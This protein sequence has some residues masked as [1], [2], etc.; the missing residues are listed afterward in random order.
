MPSSVII[1][2]AGYAGIGAARKLLDEGRDVFKVIVLEGG[3]RVGGRA[4]TVNGKEMGGTYFHGIYGHP[5]YEYA[6][7][8]GIVGEPF[9]REFRWGFCEPGKAAPVDGSLPADIR[10]AV[11]EYASVLPSG[12][13]A[14]YK[15]SIGT[16]LH[17]KFAE[18][19][20]KTGSI[21]LKSRAWRWR[22]LVTRIASG[23]ESSADVSAAW[24]AGAEDLEGPNF[25]CPIGFQKLAEHMAVGLDVRYGAVVE[26]VQWGASGVTVTCA[27]GRS[28]QADAAVVTVSLGVL[29]ESHG[30][31]FEP[32]LPPEKLRAMKGVS[33]GTVDKIFADFSQTG[34]SSGKSA[35]GD[36]VIAYHLLWNKPWE[37]TASVTEQ[38][39][40]QSPG[41]GRWPAFTGAA[42][43]VYGNSS[44]E[45]GRT[46][47]QHC[48][49]GLPAAWADHPTCAVLW[50]TGDHA[51][52]MEACSEEEVEE[53][54]A[55][56][57]AAYPAIP[58]P[59]STPRIVRSSW[60]SDP[61]FR[62]S[63]SYVNAEGTPEDIDTLAAP[64]MV[65]GR[66]VVCFAGEATH[67][68]LTGTMGAAF[69]TGRNYFRNSQ[70]EAGRLL[71]A[72]RATQ[73]SP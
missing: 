48:G 60:G 57:L 45:T 55:A 31:L 71:A 59:K 73:I 20:A 1:I 18:G 26:K 12:D 32:A 22:E 25:P 68:Q 23:C 16:L 67:R 41:R 15:N 7:Q 42:E 54:V 38:A 56:L 72:H 61:L 3:H 6:S 69:L 70:R 2:G 11:Q 47:Q 10:D 36:P 13:P 46:A 17:Q 53:G 43:C 40:N 30:R 50:L 21:Q 62:G 19:N 51:K 63:Y 64:L 5:L 39:R 33:I 49:R 65:S 28:F 52:M 34:D 24:W 58:C 37:P 27:D 14:G 8:H 44:R 66:P 9:T 35:C 4:C 29:K